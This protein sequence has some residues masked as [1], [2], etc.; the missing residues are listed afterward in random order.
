MNDWREKFE[1]SKWKSSYDIHEYGSLFHS[2]IKIYKPKK[3]VELG[4]KAGYSAYY[5]AKALKE[6]GSGSLDCYDLWELYQYSSCNIEEARENL[7]E[8]KE[9]INL[10]QM[11]VSN[12]DESYDSI[13]VLHVDLGNHGE[14]LDKVIKSWLPKVKQ[15]IIIEGGSKERDRVDWMIKYNK[16]PIN[17]WLNE[18]RDLFNFV[19]IEPFPSVTIIIK[20]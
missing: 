6:N 7:K 8:Y 14:S 16:K 10:F 4:T 12:V 20:K 3:I 18:N 19:V 5:M 15:F 17:D 9:I 11:D 2:L 1:K 13:D